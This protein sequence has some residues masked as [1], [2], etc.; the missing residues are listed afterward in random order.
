MRVKGRDESKGSLCSGSSGGSHVFFYQTHTLIRSLQSTFFPVALQITA[1][2]LHLWMFSSTLWS[3]LPR[4]NCFPIY[5]SILDCS[6][7][8]PMSSSLSILCSSNT[9][10]EIHLGLNLLSFPHPPTTA[11]LP[12]AL[13]TSVS[14]QLCHLPKLIRRETYE[15]TSFPPLNVYVLS[16]LP[17]KQ[18]LNPAPLVS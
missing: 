15:T 3:Q 1:A 16:F 17:L 4:I 12:S 13:P 2:S 8:S 14:N 6:L 5:V 10:N 9:W 18:L 11:L 7:D